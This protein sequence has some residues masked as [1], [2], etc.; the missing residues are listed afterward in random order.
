M[1][2]RWFT[3]VQQ[4][5]YPPTCLLC[6][7]PGSDGLDLCAGCL[8][9]FPRNLNP[10]RRCAL[11]LP[12]AAPTN[13][14]CGACLKKTPPFERCLAPLLYQHPVGELVSGLKFQQKLSH[15]RVMAA[16]LLDYIEQELD[17]PPQLLIPV[18]LHKSRLRERGYNQALELARPLSR[19][20]GIPLDYRSCHRTR[21]T[22]PQSALQ[23]KERH[24]NVRGAFELKGKIP[25]RHVALVDDVVTTGNTVT[26]LARLLKRHGIKRVD[27]WAVA[28]TP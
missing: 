26:E 21:S 8:D 7:A 16:L 14:L 6:G 5:I 11:P 19:H 2:H 15:G 10:C 27:V 1:T 18:P 17:E 9:D 23:L 12:E 13:A 20:L 25:A 24:K 4:L 22:E 3:Y 28:R